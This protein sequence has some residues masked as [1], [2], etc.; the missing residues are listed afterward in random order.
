[1]AAKR[2]AKPKALPNPKR[3]KGA[4]PTRR[5]MMLRRSAA[6][7]YRRRMGEPT[8]PELV[9]GS[10]GSCNGLG[11]RAALRCVDCGGRG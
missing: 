2:K 10:C 5:Q 8:K 4:A 9:R 11:E 6:N 7:R 3:A 1:M